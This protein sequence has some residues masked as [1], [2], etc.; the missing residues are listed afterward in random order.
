VFWWWCVT[1]WISGFMDF[2]QRLQ[3]YVAS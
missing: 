3:F 1:F 2:V